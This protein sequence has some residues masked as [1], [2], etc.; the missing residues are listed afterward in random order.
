V[1]ILVVA[2]LMVVLVV[3][4]AFPANG[5]EPVRVKAAGKAPLA[6]GLFLSQCRFSPDGRFFVRPLGMLEP[7]ERGGWTMEGFVLRDLVS[8]K[9]LLII[10]DADLGANVPV[11]SRNAQ[12]LA[13]G[14]SPEKGR[15]TVFVRD[16]GAGETKDHEIDV[17]PGKAFP[18]V[19]AVADDGNRVVV[20]DP[21]VGDWRH[22]L[23]LRDLGSGRELHRLEHF[24]EPYA[25]LRFEV[26]LVGDLLLAH[27]RAP[28]RTGGGDYR[29]EARDVGSGETRL[30]LGAW[31]SHRTPGF[32]LSLDGKTLYRGEG[33]YDLVATDLETGDRRHL[34]NAH[35]ELYSH[36]LEITRSPDGRRL[37][38]W[39]SERPV[40]V[41]F[42]L[43]EGKR[44]DIEVGRGTRVLGFTPSGGSLVVL[45][46]RGGVFARDA[47]KEPSDPAELVPSVTNAA[48]DPTGRTL[49]TAEKS[50]DGKLL[51]FFRLSP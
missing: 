49:V 25:S 45:G 41:L 1:R 35:E 27:T 36:W 31:V 21:E 33:D 8:G 5:E 51:R 48:L 13:W 9:N 42:A 16:L 20:A 15:L 29:L 26:R 44:R 28:G 18:A 22:D 39:S 50:G 2:L 10:E 32:A 24:L 37:A 46:S 4:A 34:G 12:W 3:P 14:H 17:R 43:P 30:A 7:E 23:S 40:V 19:A 6:Q 47:G 38:A 11:F